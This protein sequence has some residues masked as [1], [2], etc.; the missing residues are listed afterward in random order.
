MNIFIIFAIM[1]G[2]SFQAASSEENILLIE[3]KITDSNVLITNNNNKIIQSQKNIDLIKQI[4]EGKKKYLS[5]RLMAYR[6]IQKFSWQG[7]LNSSENSIIDRNLKIFKNINSSDLI[8]IE[9]LNL[10]KSEL[11]YQQDQ[12][13]KENKN[14]S[15]EI[16]N[17]KNLEEKLIQLESDKIAEM[18]KIQQVANTFLAQKKQLKLP[19]DIGLKIKFG[20]N[21]DENAQFN[22]NSKGL[23]F[24][25]KSDVSV[26][27]FGPGQVIFSDQIP[28][29]RDSLIISHKGGYYT[30]Y[31]GV[32]NIKVKINEMVEQNQELAMT[33]DTDFYFE[34]RHQEIPINPL[35]WI[36]KENE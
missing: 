2:I 25:N 4:I 9:E 10:K 35:N 19:L 34:L 20:S 32:K 36:R 29:W 27:A 12:Y 16:Q 24:K 21:L 13:E 33:T 31:S 22:L 3:K 6:Q 23:I 30:V 8:T 28:Y 1:I 26:R 14:L 11:K 7:L 5:K 17:L 15:L 18:K